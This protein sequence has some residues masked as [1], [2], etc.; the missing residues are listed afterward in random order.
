[1]FVCPGLVEGDPYWWDLVET[2]RLAGAPCP[3]SSELK[4]VP[5]EQRRTVVQAATAACSRSG[6]EVAGNHASVH[7]LEAWVAAGH[8]V[9]NHTWDHPCLNRCTPAAQAEQIPPCREWIDAHLP[10]QPRVFAYP[11]GNWSSEAELSLLS[12]EYDVG[13]LFRPS[14]GSGPFEGRAP[15]S[16]ATPARY[17][18]VAR[19]SACRPLRFPLRRLPG[20]S[21][22]SRT[23]A[24]S[25]K[26]R[27]GV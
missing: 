1:M 21:T 5:D 26:V 19:S 25:A 22:T 8:A 11:N 17:A 20:S 2:A 7:Q 10:G 9:G 15:P 24:G 14:N 16:L 23:R 13:V 18:G 4:Q 12:L 6:F 27:R 3:P